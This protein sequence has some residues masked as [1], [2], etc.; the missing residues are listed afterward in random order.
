[1]VGLVPYP[2]GGERR[3]G[4][5]ARS[6]ERPREDAARRRLPPAQAES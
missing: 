2:G 6:E 1:M 3:V 5:R 4:P